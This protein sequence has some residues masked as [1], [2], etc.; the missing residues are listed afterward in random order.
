M[1][2]LATEYFFAGLEAGPD[3]GVGH[4]GVEQ[5]VVDHGG[6]VGEGDEQGFRDGHDG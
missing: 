5:G 1:Q 4:G 2:A 3:V 6:E